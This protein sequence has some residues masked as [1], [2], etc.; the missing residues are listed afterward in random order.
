MSRVESQKSRVESKMSR[1][2]G[3]RN[4]EGFSKSQGSAQWFC[5]IKVWFIISERT[6]PVAC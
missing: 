3:Y 4:V 5:L 1:V 2:E 6:F